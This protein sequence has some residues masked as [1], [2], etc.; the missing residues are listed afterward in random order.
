MPFG[1]QNAMSEKSI[2]E[3]GEETLKWIQREQKTSGLGMVEYAK[4]PD[5]GALR[6]LLR[7]GDVFE[8]QQ[9]MIKS[10]VEAEKE[11]EGVSGF[12]D[13]KPWVW[14]TPKPKSKNDKPEPYEFLQYPDWEALPSAVAE[15]LRGMGFAD[16]PYLYEGYSYRKMA[17]GAL[18]RKMV[19]TYSRAAMLAELRLTENRSEAEWTKFEGELDDKIAMYRGKYK[20]FPDVQ[21]CQG[22]VFFPKD[23]SFSFLEKD[24][25]DT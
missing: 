25:K 24:K 21:I 12:T 4:V 1:E 15:A 5:Q 16:D 11:E 18:R 14:R 19:G 9:G 10:S 8:P 17:G 22:I 13:N 20:Q 7:S 23:G 3:R 6:F 2:Q